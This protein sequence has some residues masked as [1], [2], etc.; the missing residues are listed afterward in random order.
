MLEYIRFTQRRSITAD[1]TPSDEEQALYDQVSTYL[2]RKT[3]HALPTSQRQL[4]TMVLRKLLASSSFAIAG[5]L[6]KLADRLESRSMSEQLLFADFEG[7]GESAEEW[8][9]E[10]NDD[11]DEPD[12]SATQEVAEL[13]AFARLAEQIQK[14]AKGEALISVLETALTQAIERGAA[15][16]AVIFT[17]SRRTQDYLHALLSENGYAGEIVLINGSNDD[18]ESRAIYREW[19]DR[20]KNTAMLSGSKTADMKQALVERFRNHG[21]LLIATESAAEG[22]NLQFASLVINFDLPWNPQRIEQRIGR[23]HRYG[24]KNDV[25]VVNFLNRRNQADQRVFELLS[26]KLSLFDGVFGASDEVLGVLESGVDFEK[27]IAQVYQECRDQE[28]IQAAF[29]ALQSELEEAISA[30]LEETRRT[31]IEHFDE[32]V[33]ER[34]RMREADTRTHLE[35]R[36]KWLLDLTRIELTDAARF[37]PHAPRF[38]Y[39]GQLGPT[40]A[41]HLDWRAAEARGERFYRPDDPLALAVL[42]RAMVRE[43]P[44]V[45]LALDYEALGVRLSALEPFR[46]KSGWLSLSK[47]T[48]SAFET[49]EILVLAAVTE[50]GEALDEDLC[51]KLLRVPAKVLGD[52]PDSEPMDLEAARQRLISHHVTQVDERN[53]RYFDEEVTKLDHWSDDLK[54]GLE[55]EIKELERQIKDARRES[56]GVTTLAEKLAGQ[57]RMKELEAL[58]NQKRR[59]LYNAQD[60]IDRRREELISQLESQVQR[61]ETVE[62][63][64]SIQWSLV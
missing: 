55:Q 27:R 59:D 46:G 7:Y 40:G 10:A 5:T 26:E 37:D 17:E 24:Q 22:V 49:E 32:E 31:L 56:R 36:Q 61:Q 35:E 29:D 18:P 41:Y 52:R 53:G 9:P 48:V 57:K 33:H 38:E 6:A 1:F 43:L 51:R 45:K 8:G 4:M 20:H 23:C 39:A 34:L 62:P 3:L 14:N 16:K 64:F 13:K 50:D 28:E 54:V 47:L 42:E 2:Q 19:A 21:T 25:V 58:R 60:D 63:L 12:I 30:R 44:F 15:R 11:E